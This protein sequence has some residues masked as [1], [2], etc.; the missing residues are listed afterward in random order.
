MTIN[1]VK[2]DR[3]FLGLVCA[4]KIPKNNRKV[5]WDL[6]SYIEVHGKK[7]TPSYP[8][9][10]YT[11][12]TKQLKLKQIDRTQQIKEAHHWLSYE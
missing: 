5:S 3:F 4:F 7:L 11:D 1:L 2:V 9:E 12:I 10:N 8:L 6:H